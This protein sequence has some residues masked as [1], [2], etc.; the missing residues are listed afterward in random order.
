MSDLSPCHSSGC[1]ASK[2]ILMD[3]PR[4]VTVFRARVDEQSKL[5][6]REVGRWQGYLAKLRGKDVEVQIRLERKAH[7]RSQRGW[8]RAVIVPEVAAFLSEAKGY[9]ISN[10]QAHE[11]IKQAF[12]GV[13][14]VEV[15]GVVTTV[16]ISTKTLDTA[17]F[18]DMCT[19]IM[20]HFAPLGLVIPT[21]EDYWAK[22]KPSSEEVA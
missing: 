21:P 8:Y 18:A 22:A 17:Q 13:L 11:L 6:V 7:T 1:Q 10:D 15:A 19:A 9:V 20:A 14:T 2:G 16:G 12:I 3:A 5:V 4:P